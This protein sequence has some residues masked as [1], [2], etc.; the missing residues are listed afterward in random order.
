MILQ[1]KDRGRKKGPGAGLLAS[2]VIG[3]LAMGLM[4][5]VSG[6]AQDVT[7]WRL[8]TTLYGETEGRFTQPQGLF[9][10]Q[11]TRS[12]LVGSTGDHRL[13]F[14]DESEG[15]LAVKGHIVQPHIF[16]APRH[17]V[18][19]S[20]GRIILSQQ[21]ARKLQVVS[22]EGARVKTLDFKQVPGG[23]RLVPGSLAI[24]RS[25]SIYV[26]DLTDG[27]I[28]V[29]DSNGRYKRSLRPDDPAFRGFNAVA[30][31]GRGYV[32]GLDT[33][34]GRIYQFSPDGKLQQKFGQRGSEPDQF[35]F[36]TALAVDRKGLTYVVD[37]HRGTVL[38]FN[39]HGRFL[40]RISSKGW[41]E[42]KVY[43]PAAVAVDENGRV[44]IADRNNNRVQVFSPIE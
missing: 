21:A 2:L 1:R 44:F 28:V 32:Y 24:D 37:Q 26:V 36:P 20:K 42:G 3:A 11:S 43:Y 16:T 30:V 17:F 19:D 14:Y 15:T 23:E 41:E 13:V 25:D 31:D 35:D 4:S 8:E 12:L 29:L 10:N 18:Q 22:P 27:R 7:K 5:A 9:Y 34:G 40:A 38:V 39:R 6:M 33:L